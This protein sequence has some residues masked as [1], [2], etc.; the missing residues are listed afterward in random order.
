MHTHAMSLEVSVSACIYMQEIFLCCYNAETPQYSGTSL[1]FKSHTFQV[2]LYNK[3]TSSKGDSY[4]YMEVPHC[5]WSSKVTFAT[6]LVFQG[7]SK[8]CHYYVLHDDNNFSADDLQ[9]VTFQLCH[10]FPR[11]NRSV[12]Y[13][14]PAYCAHLVA[15]RAR[16][17]LQDW[18]DKRFVISFANNYMVMYVYTCTIVA[19]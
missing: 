19:L 2:N 11:C 12:S 7:T 6:C 17:L 16:H 8:P 5:T 15:F 18:E 4:M 10:L 13:P 9:D 14:A 3:A 1:T